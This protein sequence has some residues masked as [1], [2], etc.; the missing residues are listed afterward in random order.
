MTTSK[1]KT[2][3]EQLGI[4]HGI[5]PSKRNNLAYKPVKNET[6]KK[7][8]PIKTKNFA[9]LVYSL[10]LYKELTVAFEKYY[11]QNMDMP[12][13]K[14]FLS[15]LKENE[16]ELKA[17]I[18]NDVENGRIYFKMKE[19]DETQYMLH[20]LGFVIGGRYTADHFRPKEMKKTSLV[21]PKMFNDETGTISYNPNDH[22]IDLSQRLVAESEPCGNLSDGI[23]HF[24]K[25]FNLGIHE[26][27]HALNNMYT[28]PKNRG[29]E[30]I[31]SL[32]EISA[33]YAQTEL[34]LPLKSDEIINAGYANRDP[35]HTLNEII[36]ERLEVY[37]KNGEKPKNTDESIRNWMEYEYLDFFVG[38]WIKKSCG[39]KFNIL[40]YPHKDQGLSLGELFIIV[41]LQKPLNMSKLLRDMGIAE[42]GAVGKNVAGA[43]R[44]LL[45]IR[46]EKGDNVFTRQEFLNSMRNALTKQFKCNPA[47]ESIPDDYVLLDTRKRG[48]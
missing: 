29:D 27:A 45:K 4:N 28:R 24:I 33:Y 15:W 20:L 44:E 2:I 35:L 37:S 41:N 16:N 34:G 17:G 5:V 12:K 26:H 43:I 3:E 36:S 10:P 40:D 1:V 13:V 19:G 42:D 30:P 48:G 6:E 18:I 38:P 21:Y 31:L 14:N 25:A 11:G 39:E 23:R 9:E 46:R 7:V 8:V 47:S 32:S 22:S